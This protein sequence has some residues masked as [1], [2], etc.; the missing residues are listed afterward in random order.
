MPKAALNINEGRAAWARPSSIPS[1]KNL[2]FAELNRIKLLIPLDDVAHD[3]ELI[4]FIE[5]T[6]GKKKFFS[7]FHRL[8]GGR[9]KGH[10]DRQNTPVESEMTRGHFGRSD[11]VDGGMFGTDVA[12]VV[13]HVAVACQD[14]DAGI[15]EGV[16]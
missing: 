14:G 1:L 15:R 9:A 3:D 13:S 7:L 5:E 6:S 2:D 11:R 4:T 16:G 8:F 12:G 10:D